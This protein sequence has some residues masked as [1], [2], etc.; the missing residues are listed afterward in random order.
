MIH[1]ESICSNGGES[2][3]ECAW[4]RR[5][6]VPPHQIGREIRLRIRPRGAASA[7]SSHPL[8]ANLSRHSLDGTAGHHR[9]ARFSAF[10]AF[11]PPHASWL[12]VQ[13]CLIG[14]TSAAS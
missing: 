3:P 14:S 13:T 8:M 2:P 9:P 10:Q 1:E 11:L 7:T 12:S 4:S 5:A 6:N